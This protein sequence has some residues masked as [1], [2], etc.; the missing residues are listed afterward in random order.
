MRN[1]DWK[2][3]GDMARDLWRDLQSRYRTYCL[4][5]LNETSSIAGDKEVDF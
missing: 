4:Q 2:L 3:I 1:G 5:A